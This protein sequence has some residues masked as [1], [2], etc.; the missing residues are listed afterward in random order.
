LPQQTLYLCTYFG[1][2]GFQH[3]GDVWGC[4]GTVFTTLHLLPPTLKPMLI[5]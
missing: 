3:G 2:I 5:Q 4:T 1:G